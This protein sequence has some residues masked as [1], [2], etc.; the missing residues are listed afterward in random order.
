VLVPSQQTKLPIDDPS[1]PIQNIQK[2]LSG[3]SIC[4]SWTSGSPKARHTKNP[5]TAG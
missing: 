5:S 1:E 4:G 2:S 3:L